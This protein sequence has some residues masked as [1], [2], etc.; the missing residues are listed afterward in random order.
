MKKEIIYFRESFIQSFLSDLATFGF[1]CGSIWFNY[2]FVG[3]SYFLNG[4][5]LI[6]FLFFVM[7]KNTTKKS[8]F[9]SK[10][11]LIDYLKSN[12]EK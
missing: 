5:I 1:M 8:V 7:A 9:T 2:S 12:S 3:G 6:M 4:V 11:E 10:K